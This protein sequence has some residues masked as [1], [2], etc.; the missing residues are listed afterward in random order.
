MMDEKGQVKQDHAR[1][2]NLFDE[3]EENPQLGEAEPPAQ[4]RG[5]S[6]IENFLTASDHDHMLA[7]IDAQTWLSEL[8][9]RVQHYG[10]KYDYK[11][12]FVDVTMRL[13]DLPVWADDMG[14][15]LLEA[16]Y[17][18][19]MPDQVIVNEYLPGQGI[20]SHV[21]C[22]PCFTDTIAA[23]T[24][25]SA[26]VMDFTHKSSCQRIPVLLRPC[27]L[28]VMAGEARYDWLHGIAARQ[29]D[30]V[31]GRRLPR[32]RRVSVTFRKVIVQQ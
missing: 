5:L 13:G 6:Y 10:Y 8:K 24:L 19:E 12:R 26:C 15:R 30:V 29:S 1:Q 20:A 17:V 18:P 3:I 31:G 7:V 2:G 25:G 23:V 4:I 28:I 32:G 21:D 22:T 27:S 9:R 14:R 16:G 11:S